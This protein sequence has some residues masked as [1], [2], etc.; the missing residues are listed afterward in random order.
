MLMMESA[1]E[2]GQ[3]ENAKSNYKY[4]YVAVRSPCHIVGEVYDISKN[5]TGYSGETQLS[6]FDFTTRDGTGPG[7]EHTPT[8][9]SRLQKNASIGK[10]PSLL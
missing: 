4:N 3:N 10:T 9:I 5:M 6:L 1:R 7:L 2:V 8:A